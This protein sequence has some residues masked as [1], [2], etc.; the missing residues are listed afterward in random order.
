MEKDKT[1]RK[2]YEIVPGTLDMLIL[3]TR[4]RNREPMHGYSI[5]RYLR[6]TI[7]DVLQVR[8]RIVLSGLQRL[9]I[10]GWVN[11]R[12]ASLNKLSPAGQSNS[13]S[14]SLTSSESWRR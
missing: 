2:K 6:R 14:R 12:L 4:E 7:K 9:A 10:E 8:G 11:N 13:S 3:K 5:A 1:T